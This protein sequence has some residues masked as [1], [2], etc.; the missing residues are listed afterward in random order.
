[1]M[2]ISYSPSNDELILKLRPL[3]EKQT[4]EFGSFKFWRDDEGNINGIIIVP[5]TEE[6]EEFKKN[7]HTVRL[8]GIW[9]GKKITDWKEF[10]ES[11]YG[12]M[13]DDQIYRGEQG[14]YEI[15]EVIG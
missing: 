7:L 8:D 6:L 9:K 14:Q 10:I 15:R 12:S 2:A 5:F 3:K 4:K 1:M 13:A 11:T